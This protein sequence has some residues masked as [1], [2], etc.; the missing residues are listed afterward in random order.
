MRTIL[1]NTAQNVVI[2]YELA[3]LRDRFLALFID[4]ALVVVAYLL[5]S[6]LLRAAFEDFFERSGFFYSVLM[7][8][9]PLLLFLFYI[10]FSEILYDGQSIGKR[11]LNIKVVRIDGEQP[12]LSDY[13]IRAV[14]QMVDLVFS[15]G[16]VGALFISSTLHRQRLGDLASNTTVIRMQNSMRVRLRDLLNI[17]TL[18]SYQPSFPKVRQFTDEDM[19]LIKKVLGRYY[20]FRNPAHQQA[21]QQMADKAAE[22][23]ELPEAPG[24]QEQFLKTLIKDYIVLTR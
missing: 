14:F 20:K 11:A 19:L 13:M 23:L 8:L 5:L 12:S 10:L 2:E 16:T 6:I 21:L 15:L 22:E 3:S 4:L 1:I 17:D 7:G 18:D 24:N 9:L